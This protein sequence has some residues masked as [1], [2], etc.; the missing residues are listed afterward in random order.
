MIFGEF[1]RILCKIHEILQ[2]QNEGQM[3]RCRREYYVR[4]VGKKDE[5]RM[6]IGGADRIGCENSWNMREYWLFMHGMGLFMHMNLCKQEYWLRICIGI[7]NI[8]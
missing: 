6:R 5:Y 3:G 8:P 4:I 7:T 2:V 1:D